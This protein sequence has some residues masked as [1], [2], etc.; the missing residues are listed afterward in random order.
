M[1]FPDLRAPL[2]VG[3]GAG[4][5]QYPRVASGGEPET[6]GH[7][8]QHPVP[9][10]ICFAELPD[11]SGRHLGVAAHLGAGE[12]RLLHLARPGYTRRDGT[13]PLALAAVGQVPVLNCGDFDVDVDA[14]QKRTGDARTVALDYERGAGAEVNGIA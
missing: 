7:H 13:G 9:R 3:N 6:V 12:A 2:Q 8:L 4:H 14:V 5:L 1:L 11:H 10:L